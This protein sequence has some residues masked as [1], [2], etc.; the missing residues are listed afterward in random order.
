MGYPFPTVS[1]STTPIYSRSIVIFLVTAVQ[2]RIEIGIPTIENRPNAPA[3]SAAVRART[4]TPRRSR[5]N[6]PSQL[7]G[8]LNLIYA[9]TAIAS[10]RRSAAVP[11]HRLHVVPLLWRKLGPREAARLLPLILVHGRRPSTPL[12]RVDTAADWRRGHN[13]T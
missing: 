7:P 10:L 4:A 1:T 12:I 5:R 3:P 8:L 13:S 9:A 6:S 2:M 11:Q